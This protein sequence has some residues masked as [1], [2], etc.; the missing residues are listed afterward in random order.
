MVCGAT[1]AP[2]G[3]TCPACASDAVSERKNRRPA[4]YHCRSCRKTFSV[5]TGTLLHN[6]KLPLSQWAIAFYL[7]STNLKGVS[8]MKLH[9]DLGITQ[10][11]AWHMEHRIQECWNAAADQF[12]GPVEADETYIGGKE[13]NKHA[14]KKLNAGRGTV[15]KTAVVG[16]KDR[17][18][19]RVNAQVVAATDAPTLRRFVETRTADAAMV[20]TDEARA[21]NGLARPHES[22]KHSVGEYVREMAHTNGIESF[23]ATLKRGHDGVYHH[24][25]VKH[26]DRYV[27][28][29]E[30]R[31]NF[32]PLD[33]AEQMA[34]LARGSVGK[35]LPYADLIGKPETRHPSRR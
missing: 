4:P 30:G 14:D 31:H 8:S 34:E 5:K 20:Y 25:S 3:I 17:A 29:F 35:R 22:V 13:G 28:E 16:V 27:T 32:R 26:L 33:T 6:S 12:A 18:T 19:N 9:R 15:G 24:F 11:A 10:K 2:D 1:L 21:Y 7:F 23:W